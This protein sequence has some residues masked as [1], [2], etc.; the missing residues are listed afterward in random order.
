MSRLARLRQRFWFL[1]ALLCVLAV[2]LAEA[3]IVLDRQLDDVDLGPFAFLI[4]RVG[5]SGSRDLLGAI[6]GSMLAVASTV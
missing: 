1:P 3:L 4:T 2:V 5:E 6:A